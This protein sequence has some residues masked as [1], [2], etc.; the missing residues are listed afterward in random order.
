MNNQKY[1]TGIESEAFI[2]TP[3]LLNEGQTV[4]LD[5]PRIYFWNLNDIKFK[6]F[7]TSIDSNTHF[8]L[9]YAHQKLVKGC[10]QLS[11]Q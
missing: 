4:D 11:L 10:C 8:I 9:K 6:T 7:I 1:G 2:L 5:F 3:S